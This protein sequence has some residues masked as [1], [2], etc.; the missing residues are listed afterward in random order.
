MVAVT[1]DQLG[2]TLRHLLHGQLELRIVVA[3]KKSLP[4]W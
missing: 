2:V 4:G 1:A 3:G